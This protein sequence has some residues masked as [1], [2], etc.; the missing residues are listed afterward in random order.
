M[1]LN[2]PKVSSGGGFTDRYRTTKAKNLIRVFPFQHGKEMHLAI[3]EYL[4]FVD[5]VPQP[6]Q[7]SGCA[8]C[9]EAQATKNKRL[10]KITKYKMAVVDIDG[11]DS[12]VLCYDA[13]TTVYRGILRIIE[14][15]PDEYIG[16]NGI[17][18]IVHYDKSADPGSMYAVNPRIKGSAKLKIN[19]KDI[20]DLIEELRSDNAPLVVDNDADPRPLVKF[21]DKS[22]NVIEGRDTGKLKNKKM[23]I[24]ADGRLIQVAKK[25]I[26][27]S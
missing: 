13:P 24:E 22:G 12:V 6:C 17:D 15:D 27:E 23:V 9:E 16:N 21:K 3:T 18:M 10:R 14:D 1:K 2:I 11:D 8:I 19:K 7:G 5:N 25:D 20:P 4:H 26:I